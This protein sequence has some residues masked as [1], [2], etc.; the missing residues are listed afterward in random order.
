MIHPLPGLPA[1]S[2]P[3]RSSGSSPTA[4]RSIMIVKV[5]PNGGALP[6]PLLF[7]LVKEVLSPWTDGRGP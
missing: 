5:Q 4:V 3:D 2:P 1:S 6:I 7:L